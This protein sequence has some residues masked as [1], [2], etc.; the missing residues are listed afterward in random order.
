MVRSPQKT[1]STRG[2]KKPI[3][4]KP[5]GFGDGFL[6]KACFSWVP[7]GRLKAACR[8]PAAS[9]QARLAA[10]APEAYAKLAADQLA[11][12]P[13]GFPQSCFGSF[14]SK[15]GVAYGLLGERLQN[16]FDNPPMGGGGGWGGGGGTLFVFEWRA[17]FSGG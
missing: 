7:I 5:Q 6:Y 12:E 11:D 3:S 9:C 8:L 16:L 1:P 14:L 13:R 15:V 17:L 10:L 4:R 2:S